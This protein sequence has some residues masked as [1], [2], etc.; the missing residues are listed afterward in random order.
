MKIWKNT[1]T[2]DGYDAGLNFTENK[3]DAEIA[4]LG[5]K[6]INLNEF[7]NLRAIFRAGIGRDNVPEKEA[8]EK[9]VVVKFPSK[10]TIDIIFDETASFT[11]S[12]IFK[13]LYNNVGKL[14]PWVKEPRRQ[15]SQKKLLIIGAGKIGSRV[16]ELMKPFMQ[17]ITFDI[18]QNKLS[19]L[20]DLIKQADC[21]SLHI[22]ISDDNISFIDRE[23][24]SWIK[25]G[26]A[27]INTS[28]GAIVDEDDLYKELEK[29][30]L[31]AAFDVYWEEPY[32]GKLNNFYP[33]RFFM[34]PHV[35][36]TC[37]GFLEGCRISLDDL[38]ADLEQR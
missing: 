1:S 8:K 24:L 23:K 36:S 32:R 9:G 28:R 10:E 13:M 29:R 11:C 26:A 34:T 30:R 12:L 18:L 19:E 7:P 14:N 3:K 17:V 2:L 6:S 15:L 38:I 27:L 35:A 37:K 5:S 22:P 16:E 21:I 31:K 4:L 20:K 33:E 25:N